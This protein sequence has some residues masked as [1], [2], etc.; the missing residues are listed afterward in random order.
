MDFRI[1]I[2][3]QQGASYDTQL[4]VAQKAEALGFDGFFRSDHFLTMS[5]DGMPGPSDS[6]VT[7]GALA[8]ETSTI[9]L[10]TLV[11][12][13]TFRHP[14]LL[15]IQVAQ[16]DQMSGGRAELGLGTGWFAAEH[17][18]YGIPFP[19]KR[20]GPFEEQLAIVT[21]LWSTP[22]GETFSF[23]GEHYTLTDAP[24]LPKPVQSPVPLIIGGGGAAKTPAL[25]VKY[26]SEYNSG[27][28][29]DAGFAANINRVRT[30][31][32]AAGRDPESLVYSA[33][34]TTVV[35]ASEAEASARATRIGRDLNEVAAHG[36]G[37]TPAQVI[38]RL[39]RLQSMGVSR[40]YLQVWDL[41]D[42]DMLELIAS[43]VCSAFTP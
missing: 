3:P 16:V 19:A 15:A 23:Q 21:G 38:D 6:W 11:S 36:L 39:G 41:H 43:E 4:A 5:G 18:A 1:F 24:A 10:G 20:F 35:G 29:D 14:G 25:A 30:A 2:E 31:A 13:A 34:V 8:R 17:A 37:G 26:A 9:R 7:L 12:S 27:F 42:L 22:L 40:V 28:Q 32:E 33:A